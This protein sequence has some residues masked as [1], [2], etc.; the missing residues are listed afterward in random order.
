MEMV[1]SNI[2]IV[3]ENQKN[4]TN[5]AILSSDMMISEDQGVNVFNSVT[6]INEF[7]FENSVKQL[8]ESTVQFILSLYNNNN[9]NNSDVIN[10]Q[11]GIKDNILKPMASIL[12][13]VVKIE[14]QDPIK[15][16][17]FNNLES[18]IK[19][20]FLYC[21]TEYCLIRWLNAEKKL[22]TSIQ[23]FTINNEMCAV[24]IGGTLNYSEHSTKGVL[25]P[26]KFQ[27]KNFF[28]HGE[29]L[30]NM[31]NRV[32]SLRTDNSTISNFVQG[33]LW[34]SKIRQFEGRLVFP[35]FLY[36]DDVEINNPLSSHAGFQSISAI[37][38]SFPLVENNS[39]LSNIFLAALIKA[40]DIK[41]F[42]NDAC[43]LELINEMNSIEKEGVSIST[44]FG[45]IQI[46]FVLGLVLGDNLGL[47]SLL[48]FSKS[49]SANYYCRFC[50][51]H[52]L[53]SHNLCEENSASMRTMEN[54][55][56]DVALNNFSETG[57]YKESI[58]NK[59]NSFHVTQNYVVDIMH[60]IF[61]GVCHY[62]LCHIIKYYIDLQIFS[63]ETLN[64]RKKNFNYGPLE[65]GNLSPEITE[66]HLSKFRLKMTA[67]EMMTF[68]HY[69]SLMIGDLIPIYDE[70]WNF[71]LVFIKIIDILLSYK[72]TE[73]TISYLKQLISQH[74]SMYT[75]FF[76]DTLKPKHHF[77]IHY[78]SIIEQSGPPRHYWCFRFEGKHKEL[79]MYARTTS[80]RKNITLTLAKKFQFKFAHIILQPTTPNVSLK[81]KH[82][83]NSIPIDRQMIY[84]SYFSGN[85]QFSCYNQIEYIGTLYK[86]GYYL[87]KFTDQVCL[88]EIDEI[89]VVHESIDKVYLCTKQIELE[90]FNSHLEAFEVNIN[91]NILNNCLIL[92]IDEF[93]GPPI[94]INEVS[95]GK[96]MIRLKEFY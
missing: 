10:I 4:V 96:L 17:K 71:Y 87:T 74:N 11:T 62:N 23:Q 60:D 59:L 20:H 2:S 21:S 46:H 32:E 39:K 81:H 18:V 83:T 58:L 54:Y 68:V 42:G 52:K 13:N 51:S 63:L 27:F 9:F 25:M 57:I 76:N 16:S 61:E 93:S 66:L 67:R 30:K 8:Y 36:I 6:I 91:K 44:E 79:K 90:G 53:V 15:L 37:Y 3:P 29:N 45:N 41:E 24:N 49:F 82:L 55:A 80:S 88:F 34:Q 47:N 22:L 86:K 5:N 73:S 84:N 95:S 48:E 35:Y 31:K 89:I 19:D 40:T 50:K 1:P 7:N 26:L 56:E 64:L 94:N 65:S 72:Y 43:L 28:E 77:L 78:P 69:F 70:V 38:Y 14:I 85:S 12:N 75:H 33:K 92:G